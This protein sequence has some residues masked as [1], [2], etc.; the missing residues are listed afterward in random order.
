LGEKDQSSGKGVTLIP[1]KCENEFSPLAVSFNRKGVEKGSSKEIS[2]KRFIN[3]VN[4]IHFSEG[5]IF[6]HAGSREAAQDYLIRVYPE[7]CQGKEL[8]CRFPGDFIYD[9][10]TVSPK[11]L[12]I[13]DGKSIL[14]MPV[15]VVEISGSSFTARMKDSCFAFSG[16]RFRRFASFLVHA[17]IRQEEREWGG[18]LDDF[19][20]DGFR[21]NVMGD[22]SAVLDAAKNV[23]LDLFKNGEKIYN[24]S[25]RIVRADMK[26]KSVVLAP[27][28]DQ[29]T[30]Y[31]KRKLRNPRLNLMPTPRIAYIHPLSNQ[32]V[33]SEISEMTPTGFSVY[34]DADQSMLIPGMIIHGLSILFAGGLKLTCNAQVIHGKKKNRSLKRFGCAIVDMDIVTYNRIFDIISKA[35][36]AHANVSREVNMQALWEFFF[37]TGFLY[38]KKYALLSEGKDIFKNTYNLMY[39]DSPE[40]FANFTYQKNG[41]IYGHVSIIKAYQ[42][43]WMIHHLAAKP[44]GRR[45]TGLYVLN[46]ILNYFDGLYRMPS[47]GM[48]YMIFYFRPDNRFPDYFFGG[49]CRDFN[50]PKGC[51]MDQ[52]AYLPG[53]T[54]KVKELPSDWKI[55]RCSGGD[56]EELSKW[57]EHV[58]GGLM[59]E[60]FCL[61][62]A[63]EDE[64]PLE[65]TYARSNLKRSCSLAKLAHAGKTKAYFLVDQSDTGVNLSDLLN[66][67]KV[68]VA[69]GEGLSKDILMGAVGSLE[70]LYDTGKVPV[71][72]YPAAYADER[73]IAYEKKYNLWVLN[74]QYGDDYSE[75]MKQKA[76]FKIGK[77]IAAYISSKFKK[78]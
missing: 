44:M 19:S 22:I 37:E 45:R 75:H 33:S 64:E 6:F 71:L 78:R 1:E 59:V 2:R 61:K 21:I 9:E 49:F 38:P 5:H 18:S 4:Y 55:S 42:R 73:S 43:C 40:V 51:S 16:R 13:D 72:I 66:S 24:G 29:R 10:K 12:I 58:S 25:C 53:S 31:K 26:N 3:A 68:M 57:Y 74:S 11:N 20:P 62:G 30:I 60:S 63:A 28:G 76:Q 41:K 65:E 7:P 47:I 46:H 50:N 67:I 39:K 32:E 48:D 27:L 8:I 56:M 36:D 69:D 54:S 15:E 77:M 17:L 70:K 14:C 34:E 52:F 23:T 35:G